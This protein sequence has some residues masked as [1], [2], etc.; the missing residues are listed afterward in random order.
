MSML[1]LFIRYGYVPLMMLGV[2]GVALWLIASGHSYYWTA[3]AMLF[4]AIGLSF[5]AEQILPYEES[6]NSPHE[7]AGKDV[8]HAAVYEIQNIN[9]TLLLPVIAML[10]P[11]DGYWPTQ[12]PLLLQFLFAVVVTDIGLTLLHY[13]SH[14]LPLLWRL[15]AIHHGVHRVYGFNGFIRH[16]LH[17]VVDLTLSSLPLALLGMPV[18][19]AVLLGLAV[20]V[21]LLVQHSNVDYDL[22]PLQPWLSIGPIHR[23]HHVNWAGEGDVNFGLFFT[24]W[25]RMLGTLRLPKDAPRPKSGDVGVEGQPAFTQHYLEQLLWPFKPQSAA[26]ASEAIA[27]EAAGP[28]SASRTSGSQYSR[29]P[30]PGSGAAE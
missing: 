9:G 6:W 29:S 11:W 23:L 5:V 7:D 24:F 2:N 3:A 1:R 12:W 17:Q 20:S 18:D 25:D 27:A 16:P 22:G 4:G 10:R 13:I 28:A 15:H 14:K 26:A 21:Q 19:V 8:A 30:N